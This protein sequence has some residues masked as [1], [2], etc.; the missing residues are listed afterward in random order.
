[1]TS[2]TI[3][4]DHPLMLRPAPD[5]LTET[6]KAGSTRQDGTG[7]DDRFATPTQLSQHQLSSGAEPPVGL[8]GGAVL[9][10]SQLARCRTAQVTPRDVSVVVVSRREPADSE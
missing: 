1:V 8:V 10:P 7:S 3:P 4:P 9:R 2:D 6:S 5:P